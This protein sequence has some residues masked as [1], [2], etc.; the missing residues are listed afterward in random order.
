MMS[1][2]DPRYGLDPPRKLYADDILVD[3]VGPGGLGRGVEF[4]KV[5]LWRTSNARAQ[6]QGVVR[7]DSAA[8]PAISDEEAELAKI[9]QHVSAACDKISA[10]LDRLR[11][12]RAETEAILEKLSA[13]IQ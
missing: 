7:A 1:E 11:T 10:R 3:D 8:E 4:W 13:T 2:F 9:L 5:L 6:E 12:D